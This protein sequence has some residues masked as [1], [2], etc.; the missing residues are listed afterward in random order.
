MFRASDACGVN[1]QILGG[2]LD[3]VEGIQKTLG[4]YEVTGEVGSVTMLS[5]LATQAD[6]VHVHVHLNCHQRVHIVQARSAASLL[7]P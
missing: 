1:L 3:G 6:S 5:T 4:H 2:E 7:A